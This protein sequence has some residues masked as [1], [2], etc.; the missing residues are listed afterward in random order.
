MYARSLGT[1]VTT[2][3]PDLFIGQEFKD[4]DNDAWYKVTAA[5]T[6]KHHSYKVE[7]KNKNV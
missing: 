5:I 6:V 7:M 4:L 2:P 1:D 3:Y